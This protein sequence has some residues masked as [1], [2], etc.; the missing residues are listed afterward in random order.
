MK[1]LGIFPLLASLT[2]CSTRLL[3]NSPLAF[4]SKRLSV[5]AGVVFTSPAIAPLP[6]QDKTNVEKEKILISAAKVQWFAAPVLLGGFC[7]VH[8]QGH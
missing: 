3:V 4:W 7:S 8:C 5:S 1:F 6:L 2:S